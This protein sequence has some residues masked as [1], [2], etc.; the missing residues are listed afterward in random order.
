MRVSLS[1]KILNVFKMKIKLTK[2]TLILFFLIIISFVLR[3]V[4][5]SN[6]HFGSDDTIYVTESIGIISVLPQGS[7]GT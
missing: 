5:S 4:I 2:I 7:V 3:W 6:M 1:L